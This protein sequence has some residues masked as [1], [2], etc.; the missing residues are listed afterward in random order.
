MKPG[1]HQVNKDDQISGQNKASEFFFLNL[2]NQRN[3]VKGV[4]KH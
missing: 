1:L 4:L 2:K 3:N